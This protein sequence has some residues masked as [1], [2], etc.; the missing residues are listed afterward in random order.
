[1]IVVSPFSYQSE[2]HRPFSFEFGNHIGS[3]QPGSTR[4]LAAR[5]PAFLQRAGA[6]GWIVATRRRGTCP[7]PRG[8]RRVDRISRVGGTRSCRIAHY[9]LPSSDLP[10]RPVSGGRHAGEGT[11]PSHRM[12]P[13]HGRGL[14][15]PQTRGRFV[16]DAGTGD[17]E[18]SGAWTGGDD[19]CPLER[20]GKQTRCGE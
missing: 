16:R 2:P 17:G 19:H 18:I 11:T 4:C 7:A 20:C 5:R 14:L 1:M 8:S 3:I 15:F 6:R 9:G 10:G 13:R 12:S